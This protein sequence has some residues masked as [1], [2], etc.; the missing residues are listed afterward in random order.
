ML[1]WEE[2]AAPRCAMPLQSAL[3]QPG[4]DEAL[5]LLRQIRKRIAEQ[6]LENVDDLVEDEDIKEMEA[7]LES[8]RPRKPLER[9]LAWLF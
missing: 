5:D 7:G 8:N 6:G 3:Q 2:E 9:L 1:N 4:Y